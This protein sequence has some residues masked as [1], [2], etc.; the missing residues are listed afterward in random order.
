MKRK[1]KIIVMAIIALVIVSTS[2]TAFAASKNSTLCEIIA[3]LIGKTRED[4]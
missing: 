1:K 4:N 2:I 3:E